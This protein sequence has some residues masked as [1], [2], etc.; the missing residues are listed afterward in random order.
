MLVFLSFFCENNWNKEKNV[1]NEV[2]FIRKF[3]F[4]GDFLEVFF[5]FLVFS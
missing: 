5:V 4:G 3:Q 1:R 2:I